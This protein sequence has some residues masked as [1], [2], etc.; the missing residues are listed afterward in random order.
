M[1][2]VHD[3]AL[4]PVVQKVEQ[5][6]RISFAEGMA[7][8]Q[9]R[10]LPT[11]W[12]LANLVRERKHGD[13]TYFVH[14]LRFSQTNICYVGCTFCAFQKRFGDAGA[15]DYEVPEAVE[16]VRE[17]WQPGITEIHIASGHHPRRPFSYY[18]ELV[19]A[20]KENFP[21]AQIK[22]W[23]AAEIHHFSKISK[24]SYREV[25]AA[26]KEAGLDAMPGGGAEIFSERVRRHIAR[27]KVTAEDWLLVHRTAHEL[28]IPTNA[29]ML[30]GHIETQEE[31]L[32]HMDR[33]RQ[34][35][36]ETGGFFSFVPLAYQPEDN[37]LAAEL[38]HPGFT[39][40]IDD[41]RNLAVARIFL[42]NFPH[43]KGYWATLTPELTQVA[44]DWGVSDIDG[45]LVEEKIVHAA[46][47]P[48]AT[49]MS[50]EDLARLI[51]E[52]GRIPVER[53]ALYRELAVA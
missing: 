3:P 50:K 4:V 44:L 28:G 51:R 15:W 42:D 41:L 20:L 31:R 17:H 34:L 21:G 2:R 39:S 1:D 18:L 37:A 10:D 35:Q 22:A 26:L 7:L 46:G 49:G 24:L 33:L 16:W 45:T 27:N 19:S 52:A 23:T 36:D 13:Q 53:D 5:G 6:Q 8:Y 30:Y 25:L 48:T 38:N 32:D 43:I 9:T 14:S 47:S 12:R 11:V 29:T 40:G